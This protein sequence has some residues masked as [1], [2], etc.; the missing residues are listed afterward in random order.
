MEIQEI[1]FQHKEL[2]YCKV[3][4]TLEQ[5]AQRDHGFSVLGDIHNPTGHS[6]GQPA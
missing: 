4:Q 6:C 2:F 3:D 5:V 1:M